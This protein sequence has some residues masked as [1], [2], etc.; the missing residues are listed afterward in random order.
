M[1]IGT[2]IRTIRQKRGITIGQLCEGTGLSQGFLSLVENNKTSPSLATLESIAG[3]LGVPMAYLLLKHEER[4][5]VVR[6]NERTF[7]MFRDKHKIE[8][9]GEIGG[10]RMYISEI[11][12]GNPLDRTVNEHEGIEIHYVLK[13]KLLVGQGEDECT[14]EE[15]DTF[16]WYAFVPHWVQ[17]IGDEPAAILIVSYSDNHRGKN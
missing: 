12:P 6:R 10:M 17:N 8:H 3:Y 13:G 14:V 11:P 7:S 4:M 1:D 5:N 15:G 9:L 2:T 16:S